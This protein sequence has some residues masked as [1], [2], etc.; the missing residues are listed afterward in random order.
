EHEVVLVLTQPDRPSGRGLRKSES[1]VKVL[2]REHGIAVQQP[3]SLRDPALIAELAARRADV[4]VVAA[5][6]LLL[7]PTVLQLPRLGCLNIH[8]SLLPRWRGAAPIQRA[9]MAGDT[10]TG[11]SIMQMDEGLD[12]G[13]VL[14]QR[15]V[16]IEPADTA[17]SLHDRLAE[18]GAEAICEVL[19]RLAAGAIVARPQPAEGATYAHKITR[20]DACV[21]WARPAAEVERLLRALDPVP[22]AFTRHGREELKLWSG[23]LGRG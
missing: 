12:T 6:G 15:A 13:P 9:I 11:I 4:W 8:A 20:E 5:Y 19:D 1:P 14:L 10:Q 7:P 17:G 22:G 21:D 23:R 18:L 2:A 16:P 3:A